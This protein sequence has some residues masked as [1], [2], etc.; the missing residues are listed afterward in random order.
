MASYQHST[1]KLYS[2]S[3]ENWELLAGKFLVIDNIEGYLATRTA[4]T[5]NN[6]QYIKPELEI[7]ITCDLSQVYA[8]PLNNSFKYVS[9]VNS[10]N[11][12][13]TYYYF[14]KKV[15]WRAK[16]AVRF[17]L[18]MDV[19]NTFKEGTDYNFK[20]STRI[21]REH[22]N[23][24]Q[25]GNFTIEMAWDSASVVGLLD[26]NESV[27]ILNVTQD[28]YEICKARV[29]NIDY[30]N[31]EIILEAYNTTITQL[32]DHLVPAVS[33]GDYV[34]IYKDS[35]NYIESNAFQDEALEISAN[36]YRDIDYINE[37]INPILQCGIASGQYIS[38]KA[39]A[40]LDQ[41]WYL[42]Y[43]NQDDPSPDNLSNPVECYLVPEKE[44]AINEGDMTSGRLRAEN[45]ETGQ[46]YY[47]KITASNQFYVDGTEVIPYSSSPTRCYIEIFKNNDNSLTLTY[48]RAVRDPNLVG[49]WNVVDSKTF[50]CQFLQ[51]ESLPQSYYKSSTQLWFMNFLN[52]YWD[53]TTGSW[54]NGEA[55]NYIDSIDVLDRSEAKNIKVIKLPYIPYNFNIVNNKIDVPNSD[56][57]YTTLGAMKVLRLNNLNT[58]LHNVLN[59]PYHNYSNPLLNLKVGKLST[60]RPSK[61]DLRRNEFYES[62]LYHSE[63]YR[64]TYVYDSF[65]FIFQLEK[66][67][68]DYYIGN[69][70]DL[71]IN[72]DMTRTVNSRFMFTFADYQIKNSEESYYNVM[73]VNRNNEEVLYNVPYINYIRTGYN[74]DVKNR[75]LS[76]LSSYLNVAGSAISIGASLLAPSV[77]LKVA[78]I[79]GATVSLAMSA[80][81]A[82]VTTIQN[83]NSI[84][85]TL[86]QKEHQTAS[87]SGSDDVDLM[88]IYAN[89]RL[90]LLYYQPNAIMT[91]MLFNLFFYAGYASNRMGIPSHNTRINFDYLECDAVIQNNKNIPE[92]CIDELINCF[93]NG[94]TYIHDVNTRTGKERWDL[95][96]KYE[97]WETLFF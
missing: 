59:L 27:R 53:N 11:P 72:F 34:S 36:I 96:Q 84:K 62:K 77:P 40:L 3:I 65:S 93:K 69:G 15:L 7:S 35:S 38:D 45:L 54:D 2:T 76:N 6:F 52:D 16:S 23:R 68:M 1:V 42:V 61:T 88:S 57:I 71:R 79:V 25:L 43:R 55:S 51:M 41:D 21:I 60:Y 64:P 9:I 8:E 24:F 78:G 97:N 19:L 70:L 46:Y 5:L 31:D 50:N 90:K 75:N 91:N 14:V 30:D 49:L 74:Y 44:T 58:K 63:F 56:W 83:E 28:N 33:S 29:V 48:Y 4:T 32:N 82:V 13:Q 26:I 94:V 85:A 22:K 66:C 20:A 17:E 81:N 95:T 92:E 87:V 89:N 39:K 80:K 10:D 86:L 18:V 37:N 67:R 73:P 12:Y 47:I